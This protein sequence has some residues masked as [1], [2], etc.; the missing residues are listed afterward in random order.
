MLWQ[1]WLLD[2]GMDK[3]QY[4]KENSMRMSE[5]E[6]KTLNALVHVMYIHASMSLASH[7]MG[8]A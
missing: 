1:S 2:G 7:S 5:S 4:T 6:S 3:R 8:T